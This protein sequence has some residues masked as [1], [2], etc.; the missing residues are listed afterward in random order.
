M[1]RRT[2]TDGSIIEGHVISFNPRVDLATVLYPSGACEDLTTSQLESLLWLQAPAPIK[3]IARI[4]P[5]PL[6][7]RVEAGG[8]SKIDANRARQSARQHHD[9]LAARSRSFTQ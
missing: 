6:S 3:P 2:L 9:R 4:A 8:A 5:E 7:P 1:V